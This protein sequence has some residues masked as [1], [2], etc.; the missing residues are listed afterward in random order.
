MGLIPLIPHLTHLWEKQFPHP[1][2][3][4]LDYD[5][6][7]LRK[8]DIVYRFPGESNGADKE[9]EEARRLNIPVVFSLEDL[10]AQT[11]VRNDEYAARSIVQEAHDIVHGARHEAYGH[12]VDD[13]GRTGRLWAAILGIPEIT[14]EQV[15]LC[16]VGLKISRECNK[17]GR[18]NLVDSAGYLLCID[19]IVNERARRGATDAKNG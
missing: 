11:Y 3:I 4:W 12:P 10:R 16:M 13:L 1:Y 9:V 18:D 19:K 8:C 2:Q 5:M 17:H 7:W 6:H 14:A 15:A